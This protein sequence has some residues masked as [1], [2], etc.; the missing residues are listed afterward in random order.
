MDIAIAWE[1]PKERFMAMFLLLDF[2]KKG[3]KDCFVDVDIN[4]EEFLQRC[5]MEYGGWRRCVRF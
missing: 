3:M 4:R 1:K 2:W 5:A